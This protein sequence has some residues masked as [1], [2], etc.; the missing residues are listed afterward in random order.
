MA[1][2]MGHF[3]W[4]F[5]VHSWSWFTEFDRFV[6]EPEKIIVKYNNLWVLILENWIAWK[7]I[8][9]FS[10]R[11]K[12]NECFSSLC[13]MKRAKNSFVKMVPLTITSDFRFPLWTIRKNSSPWY[14]YFHKT[15]MENGKCDEKLMFWQLYIISKNQIWP[16]EFNKWVYYEARI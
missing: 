8:N 2:W 12:R 4:F 11:Q 10:R 7:L 3:D 1:K 6:E 15:T 9:I 16:Q 14:N 13:P 5:P